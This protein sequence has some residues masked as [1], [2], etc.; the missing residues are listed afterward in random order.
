[1]ANDQD[2]VK[3]ILEAEAVALSTFESKWTEGRRNGEIYGLKHW[4]LEEENAIRSQGRIPFKFDKNSHAVN[5]LLGTQ[6]DTRFDIY[7]YEREQKHATKAEVFNTVWKYFSDKFDFPQVETDVFLDGVVAKYGA[8]GVEMSRDYDPIGDVRVFRVPFDELMWDSNF[9]M[10]DL[11]DAYWMSRLRFYRRGELMRKYGKDKET[12]ALIE[13]AGL[14]FN[15][16]ASKAKRELWIKPEK[17]LLATREFYERKWKDKFFLWLEGEQEPE[18]VP[19][20]SQKEAD[21]EIKRRMELYQGLQ[22]MMGLMQQQPQQGQIDQL[23]QAQTPDQA[24]PTQGVN[25]L[26]GGVPP[27]E[28][29][30]QQSE[31]PQVPPQPKWE[32]IPVPVKY[33]S[34]VVAMINGVL[35][36]DEEFELGDFPYT[37][38]FS[39]FYDGEFWSVQDRLK[40]PQLF[41]NRI[42]SQID[43]W[44]GVMA[45]GLLV[46]DAKI[47]DKSWEKVLDQWG[48]TGGAVRVKGGPTM[49][50][51]VQ[52]NG[53]AP[54]MFSILDRVDANFEDALGG[55]NM[56]GIK[57]TA[58]ESGRAVLA[59]QAQAGLDVFNTLDN[60][61]RTKQNLGVKIAWF[62]SN[63][64][65]DARVLRISA[66]T[67]T[68]QQLQQGG[69]V[70][71]SPTRPN[72]GYLK[73]NTTPENTITGLEVDVVVDEAAHSPTKNQGIIN[74]L[75]DAFKSGLINQPMPAQAVIPMFN[76]P[77]AVEQAWLQSIQASQGP[78]E[79]PA[80]PVN[81]NYKDMPPDAQEQALQSLGIKADPKLLLQKDVAVNAQA[82]PAPPAPPG[83]PG[84][85]F[86]HTPTTN[87]TVHIKLTPQ[88]QA[89]RNGQ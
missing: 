51:S 27:Q 14:D 83:M 9:R 50:N 52:S 16:S 74:Q 13:L 19:F 15:W 65:S 84:H 20:D 31:S 28:P 22:S 72:V 67:I 77:Q 55:A 48:K 71:Q 34:K 36:E 73:V 5:V 32:V 81:I 82:P 75:T 60:M 69:I 87:N 57:Q 46:G 25:G 24:P 10:Y 70:D 33:V 3:D 37:V 88:E 47:D 79:P 42:Y 53:P 66:D 7:F 8:F 6:R 85:T 44:I 76:L 58:S 30:M 62:L 21:K 39:N 68:M 49:L 78:K 12:K 40:D 1:M 86:N 17:N 23:G 64:V 61:K 63:K 59:R 18:D 56:L 35:E 38:Y 43:H 26:M 80:R 41:M 45:K 29:Q 11:S 4:T 89:V 2:K 54:Q